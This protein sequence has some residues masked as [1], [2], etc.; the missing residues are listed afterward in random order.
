MLNLI[1]EIFLT[2]L[3]IGAFTFGGGYAMVPFFQSEIVGS[4]GWMSSPEFIDFLA[5]SQMTPGPVAINAPTYAGYK[6]A[7]LWGSA[8]GT[9]GVVVVSVIL[10]GIIAKYFF[11]FKDNK[12]IKSIL[13]GIK[14]AVIVLIGYTAISVGKEAIIDIKSILIGIVFF[15]ALLKYNLNPILGMVISG[16]LGAVIF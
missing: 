15:G 6:I 8:A 1:I 10:S 16:I 3:K 13:K 12:L 11:K 9:L 4:K 2:F 14:P 7:G 5:I